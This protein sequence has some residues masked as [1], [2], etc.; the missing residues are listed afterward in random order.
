MALY[1]LDLN[2]PK[3]SYM[4]LRKLAEDGKYR[5][6]AIS[7][8]DFLKKNT[9]SVRNAVENDVFSSLPDD[10]LLDELEEGWADER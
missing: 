2:L 8:S 5:I 1:M 10:S 9:E 7:A 4:F 3:H 6:S